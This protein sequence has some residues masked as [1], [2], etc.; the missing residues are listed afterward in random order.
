MATMATLKK[1]LTASLLACVTMAS[2]MVGG[3]SMN[4]N[5]ANTW[6]KGGFSGGTSWSTWQYVKP[7]LYRTTFT[8]PIKYRA[9]SSS[10]TVYFYAYK[11][12]G[13]RSYGTPMYVEAYRAWTGD[14]MYRYSMAD[15]GKITFT[16]DKTYYTDSWSP[17]YYNQCKIRI[18]RLY[19][20]TNV[21]WWALKV[22]S[23]RAYF[24]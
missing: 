18:R 9:N 8:N 13:S 16:F 17:T 2:V 3:V 7:R 5:A 12:N 10:A 1:R 19:S 11:G 6:R 20:N 14:C 22:N 15:G 23:N 21:E 4:A 24:G